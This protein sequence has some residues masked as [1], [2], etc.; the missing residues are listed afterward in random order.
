MNRYKPSTFVRAHGVF[1]RNFRLDLMLGSVL[2]LLI[3]TRRAE[4]VPTVVVHELGQHGL[5]RDAV[6]RVAR[7]LDGRRGRVVARLHQSASSSRAWCAMWSAMKVAM[8]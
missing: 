7:L 4:F 5:K 8:K 3:R 1:R 2:K 6:Q